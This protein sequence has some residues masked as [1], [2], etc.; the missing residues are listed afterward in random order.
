MPGRTMSVSMVK[1]VLDAEKVLSRVR[2]GAGVPIAHLSPFERYCYEEVCRQREWDWEVRGNPQKFHVLRP[3]TNQ[4]DPNDARDRAPKEWPAS[5][6]NPWGPSRAQPQGRSATS[7][8]PPTVVQPEQSSPLSA[9]SSEERTRNLGWHCPKCRRSW[10]SSATAPFRGVCDR[11]PDQELMQG[12][13]PRKSTDG[14]A[15][16]ADHRDSGDELLNNRLSWEKEMDDRR[17][18]RERL[19]QKGEATGSETPCAENQRPSGPPESLAP[20]E[21]DDGSTFVVRPP[22]DEEREDAEIAAWKRGIDEM[23]QQQAENLAKKGPPIESAGDNEPVIN[24]PSDDSVCS[25]EDERTVTRMDVDDE[26]EIL[27]Q[28]AAAADE[29][30]KA[31]AELKATREAKAKEAS[32]MLDAQLDAATEVQRGRDEYLAFILQKEENDLG[33]LELEA[34]NLAANIGNEYGAGFV[35]GK[36]DRPR[37][38]KAQDA[39]SLKEKSVAH[40]QPYKFCHACEHLECG[41]N[42]LCLVCSG[43]MEAV[44]YDGESNRHYGGAFDLWEKLAK[45]RRAQNE[46]AVRSRALLKKAADHRLACAA[47]L[48]PKGK[49]YFCKSCLKCWGASLSEDS[50]P[51]Q[52]TCCGQPVMPTNTLKETIGQIMA[53]GSLF[54]DMKNY[55]KPSS[56]F[57]TPPPQKSKSSSSGCAPVADPQRP[58]RESREPFTVPA[59]IRS[60]AP[61]A[62]SGSATSPGCAPVADPTPQGS[63]QV[64]SSISANTS[65]SPSKGV[66]VDCI[67]GL[68]PRSVYTSPGDNEIMKL[69]RTVCVAQLG[70]APAGSLDIIMEEQEADNDVTMVDAADTVEED[71]ALI[72]EANPAPV[73]AVPVVIDPGGPRAWRGSFVPKYSELVTNPIKWMEAIGKPRG[74]EPFVMVINDLWNKVIEYTLR[75]SKRAQNLHRVSLSQDTRHVEL[76]KNL[77]VAQDAFFEDEKRKLIDGSDVAQATYTNLEM[78]LTYDTDDSDQEETR[79]MSQADMSANIANSILGRDVKA[80]AHIRDLL[81]RRPISLGD[82]W[83]QKFRD[84]LTQ[85]MEYVEV[86]GQEGTPSCSRYFD[87][88]PPSA[89]LVAPE[90]EVRPPPVAPRV[91]PCATSRER[92][93]RHGR[94]GDDD[95]ADEPSVVESEADPAAVQLQQDID[96]IHVVAAQA[97]AAP[98]AVVDIAEMLPRVIEVI[99]FAPP[100]NGNGPPME[101]RP[102]RFSKNPEMART[103]HFVAMLWWEIPIVQTFGEPLIAEIM[104]DIVAKLLVKKP[105]VVTRWCI[106]SCSETYCQMAIQDEALTRAVLARL[107]GLELFVTTTAGT[108]ACD[109]GITLIDDVDPV[110]DADDPPAQDPF[111]DDDLDKSGG[112]GAGGRGGKP[113]SSGSSSKAQGE[114]SSS[115]SVSGSTSADPGII[116]G[117]FSGL[118]AWT[119]EEAQ[120]V[121]DQ[122]LASFPSDWSKENLRRSGRTESNL[123]LPVVLERGL[124]EWRIRRTPEEAYLFAPG[125]ARLALAIKLAERLGNWKQYD[126]WLQDLTMRQMIGDAV[127]TLNN[128]Q[129]EGQFFTGSEIA[130]AVIDVY[131]LTEFWVGLTEQPRHPSAIEDEDWAEL[132]QGARRGIQDLHYRALEITLEEFPNPSNC[133]YCSTWVSEGIRAGASS[134]CS[135]CASIS[136]QAIAALRFKECVTLQEQQAAAAEDFDRSG[137]SAQHLPPPVRSAEEVRIDNAKRRDLAEPPPGLALAKYQPKPTVTYDDSGMWKGPIITEADHEDIKKLII[138]TAEDSQDRELKEDSSLLHA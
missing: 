91:A 43:Q 90:D 74:H 27:L 40:L 5:H 137:R 2:F 94:E 135:V 22:V 32:D 96:R 100:T 8:A 71:P 46:H 73:A 47:N 23:N 49:G 16:A 30:R 10:W 1:A 75:H 83:I 116:P 121:Y 28:K 66:C 76:L 44:I 65:P 132:F 64:G 20:D 50:V 54:P 41:E 24:E 127:L 34:A 105:A 113:P 78:D 125:S 117:P 133:E 79:A 84:R 123:P 124:K 15:P 61:A 26:M 98:G 13:T 70:F 99:W 48:A 85:I 82:K 12:M 17:S 4:Y 35:R 6:E 108:G 11:C 25:T 102:S 107:K 111:C 119:E 67:S 128:V 104:S 120:Q 55:M 14:C 18:A 86:Q 89:P 29:E 126:L 106:E 56:S 95:S 38:G 80:D 68:P 31:S 115:A 112:G 42:E 87:G 114:G 3:G 39:S 19:V 45:L 51:P 101:I 109:V 33:A 110:V 77:A 21:D 59:H 9:P 103:R 136:E 81:I 63:S 118:R 62:A 69:H 138:A 130:Q 7:Q 131:D 129:I 134:F 37:Q 88:A 97:A 53:V 52:T 57:A 72:V 93:E 92:G 36:L 60:Q 122:R 58:T